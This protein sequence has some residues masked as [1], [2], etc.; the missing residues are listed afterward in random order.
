LLPEPTEVQAGLNPAA[1]FQFAA[2]KFCEKIV[3]ACPQTPP[4]KTINKA[5]T[6][7]MREMHFF[8]KFS[9]WFVAG[10]SF[11]FPF[12]IACTRDIIV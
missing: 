7:A 11:R 8:H 3:V 1:V 2:S 5:N 10:D 6:P 9:V 12:K 4:K